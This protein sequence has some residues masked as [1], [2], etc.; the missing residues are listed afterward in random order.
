MTAQR[1]ARPRASHRSATRSAASASP[2]ASRSCST[3]STSTSPRDPSSPCSA[4]TAPARPRRSTSCPPSSRP[5]PARS[6]SAGSTSSAQPDAV[7]RLIG[8]TGQISAVD[9]QFTGEENLRLMADL[10]H[11]G[12]DGAGGASPSCSS[13]SI[14]STRPR[15]PRSTYSGGMRRRLD[16]AM[17]LVGE[18]RII[19]LDEP[20]TG[21][22]P[23]SRRVMWDI[24][25]ELVA[26]GVTILLTTQYLEEADRLASPDRP[27]RRR[28]GG[29]RRYAGRA[30]AARAGR[31]RPARVRRRGCAGARRRDARPAVARRARP[32]ARGARAT[33]ASHSLRPLLDR[34][35]PRPSRSTGSPFAPPISTTCS[36]PSPAAATATPTR[37]SPPDE[38]VRHSPIRDDAPAEPR[39]G[40]AATPP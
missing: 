40:C 12:R 3:G 36:C 9:G 28:A 4:P 37:R 21:L 29:R 15:S 38:C 30:Q 5:M 14:S 24:V 2:T 34:L 33:A 10:L 13:G 11:L 39:A 18:P 20:T 17:T 7:R 35:D 27:A 16:L 31:E 32:R 25:R 8:V 22:D 1:P 26:D 19:F 6:R 23:R